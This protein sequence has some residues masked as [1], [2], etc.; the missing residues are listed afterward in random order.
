MLFL[1]FDNY[2]YYYE[3]VELEFLFF[4]F[5]LFIGY[6]SM[7]YVFRLNNDF[8]V[9]D[10]DYIINENISWNSFCWIIFKYWWKFMVNI[11]SVY[12]LFEILD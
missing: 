12:F 10:D 3:I 11:R 5:K 7:F 9:I 6:G 8:L 4:L 1:L 2:F